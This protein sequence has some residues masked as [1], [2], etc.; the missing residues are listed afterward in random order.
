VDEILPIS[1]NPDMLHTIVDQKMN[2]QKLL[3]CFNNIL[4]LFNKESI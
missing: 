1:L 3:H 2:E 4:Q